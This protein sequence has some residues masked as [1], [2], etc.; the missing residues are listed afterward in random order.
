MSIFL[1]PIFKEGGFIYL[2]FANLYIPPHTHHSNIIN[3]RLVDQ[4]QAFQSIPCL[5]SVINLVD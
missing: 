4:N 3:K 5:K 1:N 2:I